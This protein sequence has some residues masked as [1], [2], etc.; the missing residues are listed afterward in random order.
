MEKDTL[1]INNETP[2]DIVEWK[3]KGEAI[4]KCMD[5]LK[6]EQQTIVELFYFKGYTQQSISDKAKIPLGTVK[7][8]IRLALKHLRSCMEGKGGKVND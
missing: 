2:E 8:R 4:R 5:L 6:N 7:G 3:E 1:S